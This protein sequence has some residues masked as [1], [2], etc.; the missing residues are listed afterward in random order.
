MLHELCDE[1]KQK[2]AKLLKQAS[3]MH[4]HNRSYQLSTPRQASPGVPPH[5]LTHTYHTHI[6]HTH[7]QIVDLG[8]ES[9]ALKA[10]SEAASGSHAAALEQ[11]ESRFQQLQQC[12]HQ[13]AR[14]NLR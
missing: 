5:S 14:E 3:T 12:T 10:A 2:V 13:M 9:H 11:A 4:H 7:T 8:K 6:S 1:D